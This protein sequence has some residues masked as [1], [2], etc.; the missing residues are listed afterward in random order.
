MTRSRRRFAPSLIGRLI[1]LFTGAIAVGCAPGSGDTAPMASK[2]NASESKNTIGK[3]SPQHST[4]QWNTLSGKAPLVIA[5]RGA[6]GERPEHT[7]EAYGLAI[8][9]G[10]DI[11]EP[12]LVITKDGVLVARHDRYLSTT[13]NVGDYPA[14]SDRKKSDPSGQSTRTDWWVE[15]FTL[16][17]LKKLRA[18][19]P[20]ADRS[21]QFDDRF[22]IPTFKEVV[23]LVSAANKT[24]ETPIGLYP[25][26]KHPEIFEAIDLTFDDA[27]LSELE[28]F[29]GPVFI[30][31]FEPQILKRL[32]ARLGENSDYEL[33]QLIYEETSA[34]GPNISLGDL[35][36]YADGVGP[37]KTLI[38]DTM[39]FDNGPVRSSFV[40]EAHALGLTIHPWT[41]RDD[42][43]DPSVPDIETELSQY[44]RA[45]V[46][47]L[48]TDFPQT[49]QSV[50]DQLN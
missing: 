36:A 6:S 25:E 32:R 21:T 23:A 1:A 19:Q 2:E 22:L 45:G 33:I 4:G 28:G 15:D 30:Q 47:G 26:T 44:Y 27:L 13:T 50:R 38:R 18:R 42:E 37:S 9:Q 3:E 43:V 12:D 5:H 34:A 14:F 7:L 48:F 49:A 24:R 8:E 31:S 29:V 16:T 46:D 17:E 40:D 10:A 39:T 35:A 20:R 11:V 41:F